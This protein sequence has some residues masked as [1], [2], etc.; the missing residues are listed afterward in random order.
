M[1]EKGDLMTEKLFDLVCDD[2]MEWL[3]QSK[4]LLPIRDKNTN[5]K[6]T[7]KQCLDLLNSLA[8]DEQLKQENNELKEEIEELDEKIELL[9][10]KLWNCKHFR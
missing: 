1:S 3:M 2:N 7:L 4:L 6:I 5:E 8:Q 9:E 10:R